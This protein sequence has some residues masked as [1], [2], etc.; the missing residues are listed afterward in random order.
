MNDSANTQQQTSFNVLLIGDSCTDE[1]KIGT[2]ER[3]SPEA[4]VP[5]VKIVDSYKI[6]RASYRERV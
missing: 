5:I 4:P 2:V 1:Y 3:I 6:G